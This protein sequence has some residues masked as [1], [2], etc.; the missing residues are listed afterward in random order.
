[1][2]AHVTIM[3]IVSTTM[4]PSPVLAKMDLQGMEQFVLVTY[5]LLTSCVCF[6]R[7]LFGF[8]QLCTVF[9]VF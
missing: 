3:P 4:D 9:I 6:C 1:M 8:A 2:V 7:R 5:Q